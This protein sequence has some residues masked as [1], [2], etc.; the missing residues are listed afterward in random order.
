MGTYADMIS[1]IELYTEYGDN[2]DFVTSIPT[3]IK[4]AEE[5]IFYF[6]QLPFF[7]KGATGTF[8]ISNPYLDLPTDFLAAASLTIT[9]AGVSTTLLN[10]DVTYIREVYPSVASTGVPTCYALFDNNTILV[11]PTPA[12][13]YATQLDYFYRPTSLTA[14]A[15]GGTTWLSEWAYNTLLYG[16]LAEAANWMKRNAG[17]DIMAEQY[18]QRFLVGLQ[19]LKNL[20]ESR[21][22]KDT[23][24]SGEKRIAEQ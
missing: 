10:K 11:G 15:A 22:R 24:R 1:D 21:D 6:V 13:A 7:K 9:I 4:A 16:A 17:I 5:R 18:D 14:G 20:G 19:G 2:A 8:T 12:A 3:F 23:Y